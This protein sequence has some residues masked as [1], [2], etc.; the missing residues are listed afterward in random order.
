MHR[1]RQ[2]ARRCPTR[3]RS[4][5]TTQIRKQA[6]ADVTLNVPASLDA[7]TT[8]S[9]SPSGGP[10]TAGSTTTATVNGTNNSNVPVHQM[11]ISDPLLNDDGNPPTAGN[12]FQYL[13]LASL[14]S[15]TPPNG[16]D[17]VQVRVYDS[18]IPGWV[19]GP[20]VNLPGNPTL[21]SSVDPG[22]CDRCAAD[23]HRH[24]R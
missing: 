5:R 13:E 22:R 10:N 4:P 6:D 15:V 2:M 3:P 16:A 11:V 1:R 18:S 20:V 12:P 19:P 14:G 7:G 24:Q 23:L 8:K 17:T 21:P 9:I